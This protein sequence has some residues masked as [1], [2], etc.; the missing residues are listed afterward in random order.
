MRS[1]DNAYATMG[2]T[3]RILA[4][5]MIAY[6]LFNHVTSFAAIGC[7]Y[8]LAAGNP[9]RYRIMINVGIILHSLQFTRAIY[10]LVSTGLSISYFELLVSPV[11]L[12]A[13]IKYY[14]SPYPISSNVLGFLFPVEWT[15]LLI[16]NQPELFKKLTG[17][18]IIGTV[19][20][21]YANSEAFNIVQ[22]EGFLGFTPAAGIIETAQKANVHAGGTLLDIGSGAGGPACLLAV[23]FDLDVTGVDL[24]DRN[25]AAASS[26]AARRGIS[27]KCRFIQ[28]DALSLSFDD[29]A[30]DYVFGMD[31][32]C[33]VPT[34]DILLQECHRVLKKGGTIL[35]HDWTIDARDSEGFRF[36]YAFPPLETVDSYSKKL[37][38]T[39]FEVLCAQPRNEAFRTH[40]AALRNTLRANKHRMVETCGRELYDNWN[41]VSAYTLKMIETQRLGSGR[42]IAR[43]I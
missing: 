29:N 40:V 10:C 26:L 36:I 21:L 22:E 23:E 8:L 30:F 2:T 3:L 38:D 1:T 11:M 7:G 18:G 43:K 32:W 25:V 37:C 17:K 9:W 34:R 16:D 14:P 24:L 41:L 31:A 20:G 33:H 27:D 42:F 15:I 5:I 6:G 13:I 35:F 12:F 39:G 28:S 4:A 19:E